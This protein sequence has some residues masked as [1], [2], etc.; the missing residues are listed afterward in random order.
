MMVQYCGYIIDT[1]LTSREITL[2]ANQLHK[3]EHI[4]KIRVFLV[5]WS[6][7][8]NGANGV[9]VCYIALSIGCMNVIQSVSNSYIQITSYIHLQAKRL[10]RIFGQTECFA[11]KFIK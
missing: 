11:V 2:R 1:N 3:T 4:S 9:K 6:A 7:A 8:R 5:Y 10:Q